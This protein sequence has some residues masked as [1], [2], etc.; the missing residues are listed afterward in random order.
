[1]SVH[2]TPR[3]RGHLIIIAVAKRVA[4]DDH[5]LI[6]DDPDRRLLIVRDEVSAELD[7]AED[8]VNAFQAALTELSTLTGI[9]VY[10]GGNV[11]LLK[12][13]PQ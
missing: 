10:V 2:R 6:P 4:F 12:E 5:G 11:E 1:M 3:Q 8:R 7:K 13:N 9:R